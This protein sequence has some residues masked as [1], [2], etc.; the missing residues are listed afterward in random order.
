MIEKQEREKHYVT[1]WQFADENLKGRSRPS[2]SSKGGYGFS[3][4]WRGGYI[5]RKT[6]AVRW[7]QMKLVALSM[8]QS[9]KMLR[10][11]GLHSISPVLAYKMTKEM[12]IQSAR[13][14]GRKF[15]T[16]AASAGS[17]ALGPSTSTHVL[18]NDS[19]NTT[20]S[21]DVSESFARSRAQNFDIISGR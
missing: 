5:V 15:Y 1:I 19:Y 21:K 20:D 16:K 8:M 3:G 6:I 13:Y 2:V 11:S 4:L 9:W 17:L 10:T 14:S 12:W 18:L 7:I